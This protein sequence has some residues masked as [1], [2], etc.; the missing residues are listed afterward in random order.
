VIQREFIKSGYRFIGW[1]FRFVK[2]VTELVVKQLV[3]TSIEMRIART[4][5]NN[6]CNQKAWHYCW[7]QISF[8]DIWEI[9]MIYLM[10]CR[11]EKHFWFENWRKDLEEANARIFINVTNSSPWSQSNRDQSHSAKNNS[12]LP[13]VTRLIDK[14]LSQKDHS[15]THAPHIQ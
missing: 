12:L 4:V 10:Q 5:G 9:I 13:Q 15:L 14:W 7:C 3:Y 2:C 1:M 6:I 11:G 8:T